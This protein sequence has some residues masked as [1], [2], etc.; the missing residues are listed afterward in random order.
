VRS[1]HVL[2]GQYHHLSVTKF[3]DRC[4]HCSRDP[5][6]FFFGDFL[7][8][9]DTSG[10][11]SLTLN[12]FPRR[13]KRRICSALRTESTITGISWQNPSAAWILGSSTHYVVQ[14]RNLDSFS[15][16]SHGLLLRAFC[17]A[18]DARELKCTVFFSRSSRIC[19]IL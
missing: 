5:G 12:S 19:R 2:I 10:A 1:V 16:P 14:L 8:T 9:G 6:F 15:S 3:V 17:W 4:V 11:T 13:G 7:V 18:V